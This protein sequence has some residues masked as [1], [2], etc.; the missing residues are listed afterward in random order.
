MDPCPGHNSCDLSK[1]CDLVSR[2][3]EDFLE[4]APKSGRF[5]G[6]KRAT[7]VF[8]GVINFSNI[9]PWSLSFG[10][11]AFL[12]L[13]QVAVWVVKINRGY[14]VSCVCSD[15]KNNFC[16]K[17]THL[18]RAAV[19]HS[20]TVDINIKIK[21]IYKWNTYGQF[22]STILLAPLLSVRQFEDLWWVF[23]YIYLI[24]K[25]LTLCGCGSPV[26]RKHG[27]WQQCLCRM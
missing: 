16:L 13:Q 1:H 24:N 17:G 18:Y 20:S 3:M 7:A 25:S 26:G 27:R 10:R 4:R 9:F 19:L 23:F 5:V 8:R 21:K 15:I 11:A 2:P 14:V 6:F 22:C 12:L